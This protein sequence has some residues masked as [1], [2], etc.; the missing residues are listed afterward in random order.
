[1][2]TNKELVKNEL[3]FHL[4]LLRNAIAFNG[5]DKCSVYYAGL[6][7]ETEA[8]LAERGIKVEHKKNWGYT[9]FAPKKGTKAYKA[10]FEGSKVMEEAKAIRE[11]KAAAEKAAAAE[12]KEKAKKKAAAKAE[13]EKAAKEKAAAKAAKAK[14]KEK[15]EKKAAPKAEPEKTEE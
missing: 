12:K 11:A 9:L 7:K 3:N 2:T 15:A 13:K 14:A 5:N 10:L 1:M 6:H 4:A 8:M